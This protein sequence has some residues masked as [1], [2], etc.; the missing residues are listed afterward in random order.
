LRN[1]NHKGQSVGQNLSKDQKAQKAKTAAHMYL[2]RADRPSLRHTSTFHF[3]TDKMTSTPPE[4]SPEMA[5]H[6]TRADDKLRHSEIHHTLLRISPTVWPYER[7]NDAHAW[8]NSAFHKIMSSTSTNSALASDFAYRTII[9]E[10][11][12]RYTS[13]QKITIFKD[14]CYLHEIG[15]GMFGY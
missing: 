4:N 13:E 1:R 10:P 7:T 2:R 11:P 15:T 9:A 14:I 6:H 3:G 5:H 12:H 8:G